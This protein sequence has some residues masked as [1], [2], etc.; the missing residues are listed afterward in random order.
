MS[1]DDDDFPSKFNKLFG[2]PQSEAEQL[3]G[4]YE[5]LLR[6]VSDLERKQRK[7]E[8]DHSQTRW[9]LK[10]LRNATAN[11]LGPVLLGGGAV[12]FV[13]LSEAQD[14]WSYVLIF[15]GAAFGA[16]WLRDVGRNFDEVTKH[17]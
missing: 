15:G 11:L 12:F 17:P 1:E 2:P 5:R 9:R 16:Y 8:A 4:N 3:K 13:A 7:L 14:W 6:R 10:M